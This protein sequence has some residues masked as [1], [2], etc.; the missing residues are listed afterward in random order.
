MHTAISNIAAFVPVD[1]DIVSMVK[2]IV[3]FAAAVLGLG[4]LFRIF[5]GHRSNLNHAV[6]SSIGIFFLYAATVLIYTFDP[7]GCS[8]FLAPLPLAQINGDLLY[9]FSFS[10]A[11]ITSI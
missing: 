2:F 5:F 7:A 9:L 10:T 6:S 11:E 3:I 1:L 4:L 8:R